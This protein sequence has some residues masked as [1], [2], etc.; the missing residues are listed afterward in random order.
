MGLPIEKRR[1]ESWEFHEFSRARRWLQRFTLLRLVESFCQYQP[2]EVGG[3][4]RS[5][6]D[7]ECEL[8]WR[9]IE[10]ALVRCE[11][12]TLLDLGCA[13]GFFV[14]RV[15]TE[16]GWFCLGV[17]GDIRRVTVAQSAVLLDNVRGTAFAYSLLTPEFVRRLPCFDVV[18]F[19]SILHHVMIEHGIEYAQNM[20]GAIRSRTCVRLIFD[21]GQSDEHDQEWSKSLPTMFPDPATWIMAFLSECG[22]SEVQVIGESSAYQGKGSR[23]LFMA[24]P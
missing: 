10:K 18:L 17:D 1:S 4:K 19:L 13:E 15:A 11:A 23:V 24:T 7:R 16:K 14:R 3:Q 2:L 20:M 22:F 6:G 8:R 5:N 9:L 12:N 21:M